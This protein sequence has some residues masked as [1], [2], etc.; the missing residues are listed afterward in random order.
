MVRWVRSRVGI[1]VALGLLLACGRNKPA[2]IADSPS[3]GPVDGAV[4]DVAAQ[5]ANDGTAVVS[6]GSGGDIAPGGPNDG[7]GDT[8]GDGGATGDATATTPTDSSGE[9]TATPDPGAADSGTST[10]DWR[11][12][13]CVVNSTGALVATS[14]RA[15]VTV[16][17]VDDGM[18]PD[19][20]DLPEPAPPSLAHRLVVQSGG[21]EQFSVVLRYPGLPPDLV[22]V[23]DTLDFELTTTQR[24]FFFPQLDQVFVL[25]RNARI[26][27]FGARLGMEPTS[28][29]LG[30]S[31]SDRLLPM[32]GAYGVTVSDGGVS[33]NLPGS[34]EDSQ[35]YLNPCGTRTHRVLVTVAGQTT[36]VDSG[37][38]ARIGQLSF[39]SFEFVE[40][41]D[42]G[43]CDAQ[44]ITRM[45]GFLAP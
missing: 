10:F 36:E 9:E 15:S 42:G 30:P 14:M 12:P 22:N 2:E 19:C 32:L 35:V 43:M 21:G 16:V 31:Q 33:S 20:E 17:A 44:S 34:F 18:A 24:T 29:F 27:I 4:G 26:V 6:S 23:G 5:P 40:R 3:V 37:S 8:A 11:A 13:G 28:Y 38:T 45:G 25:S 41:I 7:G 1:V 39:S